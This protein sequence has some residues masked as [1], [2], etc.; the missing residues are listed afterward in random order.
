MATRPQQAVLF[1]PMRVW[2]LPTRLFHWALVVLIAANYFAIRFDRVAWH[3]LSGH[4]I[5]VLLLW[6]IFWGLFGSETARFRHFLGNPLAAVR[7][8]LHFGRRAPD[9]QVGHNAAGGWMVAGMLVVLLAQAG[10]GLF[11]RNDDDVV[12]GPLSKLIDAGLSTKLMDLHFQIWAAIKIVVVLHVLALL[13]YAVVKRHNLLRPMV[14]GKKRLPATTPA[15]RMASN[16]R[17][18]GLLALAALIVWTA[19]TRL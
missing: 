8:L 16:L 12:E 15:P 10:T 2:D 3:M 4:A 1:L 13:A 17:A 11:G 5:T 9:T 6:R 19:V 18:L 14:T 7:H